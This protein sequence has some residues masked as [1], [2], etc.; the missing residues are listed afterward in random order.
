MSKYRIARIGLHMWE[1][2]CISG[3]RGSG[4]IFFSGCPLRCV[5]CQNR[6]VSRG[7]VGRYMN[8]GSLIDAMLS[9][10]EQGAH[11]INLVTPDYWM[12]SLRS[13]I[14]A[15]RDMGLT[16]PVLFNIGGWESAASL[17]HF[18]GLAD[19]YLT[20]FKYWD[21]DAAWRYSRAKSYKSIAMTALD[22][23]HRQ[24]PACA[25][26]DDGMMRSGIIVRHLLLPGHRRDAQE[27]VKYLY[28]TYGD[29]IYI[30]L[31]SQ[32]TP[33]DI[34]QEYAELDRKVT[35][36]EYESLVDY[37]LELGVKNCF[38][39]EGDVAKESFIPEF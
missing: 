26:D 8:S 30:S 32:Y 11:N 17:R 23:M 25:F 38:I 6:R 33:L 7:E 36:R 29:D 37:A 39:Q 35:R 34:P 27:I 5:Y 14:A 1:E 22:E 4:T 19:I 12:P 13:D 15:A 10:Q 18:D 31:M 9:L 3:S 28:E 24:Q 16:I 2:P 21:D 20:D